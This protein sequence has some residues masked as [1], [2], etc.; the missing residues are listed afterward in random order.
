MLQAVRFVALLIAGMCFAIASISP[1]EA[2]CGRDWVRVI[3][4]ADS[5]IYA[6][7]R[8]IPLWKRCAKANGFNEI[9]WA[10]GEHYKTVCDEVD[11]GY[12][13][14]YRRNFDCTE[15]DPQSRYYCSLEVCLIP[16]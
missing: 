14:K 11:G 13:R 6:E 8:V 1:S 10:P 5:S 3:V 15:G 2:R 9:R 4:Y 16:K 12:S 7:Q